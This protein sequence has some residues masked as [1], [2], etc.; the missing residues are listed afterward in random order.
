MEERQDEFSDHLRYIIEGRLMAGLPGADFR[1]H[2]ISLVQEYSRRIAFES[3]GASPLFLRFCDLMIDGRLPR[4]PESALKVL[5]LS[6]VYHHHS[7][8]STGLIEG[9]S[10]MTAPAVEEAVNYLR[11]SGC[12]DSK[13]RKV[14]PTEYHTINSPKSRKKRGLI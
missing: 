2:I 11:E 14:K 13:E 1:N 3:A 12:L 4:I 8:Q 9:L 7:E 6:K 5:V 10:G